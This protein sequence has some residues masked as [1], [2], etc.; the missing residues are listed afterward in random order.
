MADE[1]RPNENTEHI[2]GEILLSQT[3]AG[4]PTPSSD[5]DEGLRAPGGARAGATPHMPDKANLE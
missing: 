5:M 2:T 1:K 4:H 3:L